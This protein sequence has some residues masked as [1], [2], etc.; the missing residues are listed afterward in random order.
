MLKNRLAMSFQKYS[1]AL[2]LMN[3]NNTLLL[4]VYSF[5]IF[6]QKKLTCNYYIYVNTFGKSIFRYNI[7]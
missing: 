2:E 6:Y 7:L 3:I 4:Y 5:H 1:N